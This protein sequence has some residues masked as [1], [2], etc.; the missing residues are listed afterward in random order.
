MHQCDCYDIDF[1]N[2]LALLKCLEVIAN[3]S[4]KV[5]SEAFC[6]AKID[7]K[8]LNKGLTAW[9]SVCRFLRII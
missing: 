3:T 1:A 9:D 6:E 7:A 4:Q 2:S 8:G 5:D